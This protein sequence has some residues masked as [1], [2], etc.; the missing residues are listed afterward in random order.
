M[1]TSPPGVQPVAHGRGNVKWRLGS[2]KRV[3]VN[4]HILDCTKHAK[5]TAVKTRA[6]PLT[7]NDNGEERPIYNFKNAKQFLSVMR[8]AREWKYI[9]HKHLYEDAKKIHGDIS[10]NTMFID[11]NGN[12]VLVDWDHNPVASNFFRIAASPLNYLCIV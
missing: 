1:S 6:Y 2:I 8:D 12:G 9:A 10:P 7:L 3:L 5:D 4:A 11:A